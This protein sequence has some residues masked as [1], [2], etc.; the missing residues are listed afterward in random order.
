MQFEDEDIVL[1]QSPLHQYLEEV[2]NEPYEKYSPHNTTSKNN[3]EAKGLSFSECLLTKADN[4]LQRLL[5][6][7]VAEPFDVIGGCDTLLDSTLLCEEDEQLLIDLHEQ[8]KIITS[9]GRPPENLETTVITYTHISLGVL[10]FSALL[11]II[12][13]L[14]ILCSAVSW[15]IILVIILPVLYF[16]RVKKN[17]QDSYRDLLTS[18]EKFSQLFCSYNLQIDKVIRHLRETEVI[19]HGYSQIN[20][21]PTT[22]NGKKC[23]R[24]RCCLIDGLTDLFHQLRVNTRILMKNKRNSVNFDYKE[25]HIAIMPLDT[26]SEVLYSSNTESQ[27][28]PALPRLKSAVYLYRAQMSEYVYM[29]VLLLF[30][31][32]HDKSM[33][34]HISD[35]VF[36][37]KDLNRRIEIISSS[38][39]D[40]LSISIKLVFEKK[41]PDSVKRLK[42]LTEPSFADILHSSEV[43]MFAALARI[44]DLKNIFSSNSNISD[45]NSLKALGIV[46]S[47]FVLSIENAR[48]CVEEVYEKTHPRQQSGKDVE[49]IESNVVDDDAE[50]HHVLPTMQREE[51][52]D[53][54]Y[55]GESEHVD[56]IPIYGDTNTEDA[57]MDTRE[58]RKLMRELK[59]ILSV[60]ESPMGL[61]EFPLKKI[62]SEKKFEEDEHNGTEFSCGD[63]IQLQTSP[64]RKKSCKSAYFYDPGDTGEDVDVEGFVLPSIE[65]FRMPALSNQCHMEE[66][67]FGSSE[68]EEEVN[69]S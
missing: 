7:E 28:M 62:P 37:I 24:L 63:E 57:V 19:M 53:V 46:F 47:Q 66:V 1:C 10:T 18:V 67:A 22:S 14:E 33:G 39:D 41:D 52:G 35:I 55:E 5:R 61:M 25:E 15:M 29:V 65:H 6:Y 59:T 44:E 38:L 31:L 16:E 50:L 68:E 32:H 49:G 54:L 40:S 43:H 36:S 45:E 21:H 3:E 9:I 27:E 4:L 2:T 17:T 48:Y 12:L 26:F 8:V 64:D 34:K 58:S 23:L 20:K 11:P 42:E 30:A 69:S 51:L 60:K 56:T 13:G